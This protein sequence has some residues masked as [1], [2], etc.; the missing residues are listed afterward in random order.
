MPAGYDWRVELRRL[1]YFVAVAEL[2]NVS[3]SKAARKL[4]VAQPA[5]RRQVH[6]LEAKLGVSSLE[7]AA[8]GVSLTES[9]TA[10]GAEARH[11]LARADAAV[12]SARGESGGTRTLLR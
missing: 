8:R 1:R 12:K 4:H 3:N 5:L 6:D 10:F 2:N 7:R 11:G 9:G